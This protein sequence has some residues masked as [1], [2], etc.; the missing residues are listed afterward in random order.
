MKDLPVIREWID[1]TLTNYTKQ[2]GHPKPSLNFNGDKEDKH[3]HSNCEP[4]SKY[5][6]GISCNKCNTLYIN[7]EQNNDIRDLENT[8][9]HELVHLRFPKLRHGEEFFTTLGMILMGKRYKR[10]HRRNK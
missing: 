5:N 7:I 2:I 6:K 8:I 10:V 9:V 4:N 3:R 1:I